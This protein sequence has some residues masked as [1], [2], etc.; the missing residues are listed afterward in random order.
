MT[1]NKTAF[2][3]SAFL[4]STEVMAFD[5]GVLA[6]QQSADNFITLAIVFLTVILGVGIWSSLIGGTLRLLLK[7]PIVENLY[8]SCQLEAEDGKIIDAHLRTIGSDHAK[9]VC[10]QAVA[11][12]TSLKLDLSSL[13]GFGAKDPAVKATIHRIEVVRDTP[14]SYILSI[15][16]G[17]L[18]DQVA[19]DLK[20]YISQL[21]GRSLSPA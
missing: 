19:S 10:N 21:A 12:G 9:V 6:A 4:V 13:P 3:I 11:K 7:G 2:S 8:L 15:H 1:I 14:P 17:E 16:W 18:P 20:S 5:V